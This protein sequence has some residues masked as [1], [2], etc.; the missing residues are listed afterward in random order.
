MTKRASM[1]KEVYERIVHDMFEKHASVS[2]DGSDTGQNSWI[3]FAITA[4]LKEM[5]IQ[6]EEET[7]S[8]RYSKEDFWRVEL[9]KALIEAKFGPILKSKLYRLL[10]EL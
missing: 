8:A 7:E 4:D 2:S 6:L 5:Q 1:S 10:H 9:T 3:E